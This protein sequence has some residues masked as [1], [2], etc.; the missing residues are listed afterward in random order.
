MSQLSK[1]MKGSELNVSEYRE[2]NALVLGGSPRA[3]ARAEEL[4][5]MVDVP[6]M[7]V[8]LACVAECGRARYSGAR[9]L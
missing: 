9:V 6:Q 5:K 2:Q 1:F 8:T 7:Q 3:I 4:L